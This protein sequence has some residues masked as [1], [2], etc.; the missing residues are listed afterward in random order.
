MSQD[1]PHLWDLFISHASEDK[2]SFVRPLAQTLRTLG[3]SVWYDE[4]SLSI[5]DSLS[6]SIDKGIARSRYGIVVISRFFIA[7]RWPEYEL[8]GLVTREMEGGKVILPIWHRVT[9]GDVVGFSPTL[10]DTI[11]L[12]TEDAGIDDIAIQILRQVR[13]DLYE[14]HT[15]LELQY[16]ANSAA[17]RE[18]KEEVRRLRE[19]LSEFQCPHCNAPVVQKIDVPLDYDEKHWDVREVFECGFTKHAG[20]IERFCPSDEDAPTIAE[21]ELEIFKN[22]DFDGCWL[23]RATGKSPRA[24]KLRRVSS[25]GD[26]PE[27]AKKGLIAELKKLGVHTEGFAATVRIGNGGVLH[28]K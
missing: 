6:R 3:I 5:G 8:R 24:L 22:Q 11:A 12:R 28:E 27:Q 23:S 18:P 1:N 14:K 17:F 4:F 20:Q 19:V 16:L 21:F 15:R 9:R 7:K 2:E 10:A 13:P 26:D 25:Y